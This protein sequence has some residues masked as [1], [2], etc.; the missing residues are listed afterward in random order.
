MWMLL[1]FK[2]PK[3]RDGKGVL[4]PVEA[5]YT[6]ASPTLQ[7]T[8]VLRPKLGCSQTKAGMLKSIFKTHD[9]RGVMIVGLLRS[10]TLYMQRSTLTRS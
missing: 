1:W 9:C 7:I 3:L 8:S 6:F 10:W 4:T 5:G 2:A